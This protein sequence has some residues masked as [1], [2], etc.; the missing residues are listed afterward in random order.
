MVVKYSWC[1]SSLDQ[2]KLTK[3]SETISGDG[4]SSRRDWSRKKRWRA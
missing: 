4:F 2:G 3:A 1:I